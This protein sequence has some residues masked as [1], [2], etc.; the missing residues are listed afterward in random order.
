M[1]CVP[2]YISVAS[3]HLPL[4]MSA[5]ITG[6]AQANQPCPRL[7]TPARTTERLPPPAFASQ[8]RVWPLCSQSFCTKTRAA[9]KSATPQTKPTPLPKCCTA[10]PSRGVPPPHAV[11]VPQNNQPCRFPSSYMQCR[12]SARLLSLTRTRPPRIHDKDCAGTTETPPT[13]ARDTTR[14][15]VAVGAHAPVCD[16]VLKM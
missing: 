13:H 4:Q 5:I 8:L 1:S 15:V 11:C 2:A 9:H 12:P 3:D 14:S 10:P 7:Y 16:T 6:S